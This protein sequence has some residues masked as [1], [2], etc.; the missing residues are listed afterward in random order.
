[1]RG[2]LWSSFSVPGAGMEMSVDPYC[3]PGHK[4][5]PRLELIGTPSAFDAL[6]GRAWIDPQ[7]KPASNCW[8]GVMIEVSTTVSLPRGPF[9]QFPPAQGTGPATNPLS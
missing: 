6:G 4:L 5:G 8:S 3:D 9:V 7:N 2:G 1:M